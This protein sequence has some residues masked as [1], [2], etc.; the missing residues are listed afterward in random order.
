MS[1]PGGDLDNDLRALRGTGLFL[2][3]ELYPNPAGLLVT[4]LALLALLVTEAAA[5]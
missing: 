4:E 3:G 1:K 2:T 5:S